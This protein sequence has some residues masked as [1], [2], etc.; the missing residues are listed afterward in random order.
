MHLEL[1]WCLCRGVSDCVFAL[2][3]AVAGAV[4]ALIIKENP[5]NTI[6]RVWALVSYLD[7]CTSRNHLS[8]L[9]GHF[10]FLFIVGDGQYRRGRV[11]CH[12]S[13]E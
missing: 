10:V 12:D 6:T 7:F 4:G 3:T 2:F 1:D 8:F 9:Q 11:L 13:W 5:W